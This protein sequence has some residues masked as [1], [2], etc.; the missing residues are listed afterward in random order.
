[1]HI[2]KGER[3]YDNI[4]SYLIYMYRVFS[5]SSYRN[6]SEKI[7]KN[8]NNNDKLIMEKINS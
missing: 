5:F 6:V 4:Y 7:Y 2:H 3:L 1:M 8:N